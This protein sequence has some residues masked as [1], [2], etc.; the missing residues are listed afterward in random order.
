MTAVA[1]NSSS[2]ARKAVSIKRAELLSQLRPRADI[3]QL[4]AKP[5]GTLPAADLLFGGN[6]H[7]LDGLI[8]RRSVSARPAS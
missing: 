1:L 2:G 6:S 7:P 5:M 4:V 8:P 3:R